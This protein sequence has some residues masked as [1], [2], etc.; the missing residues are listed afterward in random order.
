V[1]AILEGCHHK[2]EQG[3]PLH[4]YANNYLLPLPLETKAEDIDPW[5]GSIAAQMYPCYVEDVLA[6]ISQGT[7]D[8]PAGLCSSQFLSQQDCCKFIVQEE[9]RTTC[10]RN[11][12][13]AILFP[14]GDLLAES[15]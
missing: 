1:K 10:S 6:T 5:P 2:E 7:V 15:Y 3:L 9:S 4:F 11:D 13:E 14:G 12:F 8:E